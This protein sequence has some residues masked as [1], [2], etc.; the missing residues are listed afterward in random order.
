MT[1]PSRSLHLWDFKSSWQDNKI[2]VHC[3]SNENYTLRGQKERA[4]CPGIRHSRR[5]KCHFAT[6]ARRPAPKLA[7]ARERA[8]EVN[9]VSLQ[10]E[11]LQDLYSKSSKACCKRAKGPLRL[12]AWGIENGWLHPHGQASEFAALTRQAAKPPAQEG[13]SLPWRASSPCLSAYAVFGLQHAYQ[14]CCKHLEDLHVSAPNCSTCEPLASHWAGTVRIRRRSVEV[15]AQTVGGCKQ[16]LHSTL[17]HAIRGCQTQLAKLAVAAP[18]PAPATRPK[19][20]QE[21]WP[22]AMQGKPL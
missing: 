21:N 18:L 5:G 13:D 16:D 19:A 12:L 22:I 8:L 17:C 2:W 4:P 7:T 15:E 1:C 3:Q 10:N 14:S 11:S 20:Q 6:S 9:V